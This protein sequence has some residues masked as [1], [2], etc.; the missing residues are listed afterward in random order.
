MHP[1]DVEICMCRTSICFLGY[2]YALCRG[3]KGKGSHLCIF[4]MGLSPQL[5]VGVENDISCTGKQVKEG[6][7]KW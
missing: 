1:G 5:D 6:K 3:W 2:P 7:I 4:S